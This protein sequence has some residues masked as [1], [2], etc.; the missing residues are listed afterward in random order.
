MIISLYNCKA[1]SHVLN[2]SSYLTLL[3]TLEGVMREDTEIVAP[4]IIVELAENTM[5]VVDD[6]DDYM[7][8]EDDYD[9]VIEEGLPIF[10]YAYIPLFHRYYFVTSIV[11]LSSGKVATRLFRIN[12]N[13]DVLMSFKDD[14]LSLTGMI[15]RNEFTYDPA[16]KDLAHPYKD[17]LSRQTHFLE[18]DIIFDVSEVVNNKP[19]IALSVFQERYNGSWLFDTL[20][21]GEEALYDL[22]GRKVEGI[23]DYTNIDGIYSRNASP[24][25]AVVTYILSWDEY[26]DFMRSIGESQKSFIKSVIAFPCNLDECANI[27][28]YWIRG[29]AGSS[30]VTSA[31]LS[32]SKTGEFSK[33][34]KLGSYQ[35]STY[36]YERDSPLS[37]W[38]L[39]VPFMGRREIDY[40][41]F[42]G[43][44]VDIYLSFSL[45]DGSATIYI[46][47]RSNRHIQT[48]DF[49]LGHRVGIDSSNA[50]EIKNNQIA[51]ALNGAVGT[52]ANLTTMVAGAFLHNPFMI[53]GGVTGETKLVSGMIEQSLNNLPQG[54]VS[55]QSS[56]M[57]MTSPMTIYIERVFKEDGL[58][59]D[60]RATYAHI[61][62]LPLNKPYKLDN[63]R[64][65]TK[66]ADIH[67]E[68]L[69]CTTGE[70]DTIYNFLKAG[71]IL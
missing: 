14:L 24:T 51:M 18:G 59:I 40:P 21:Q 58:S 63:L 38:Y 50:Q 70:K 5:Y 60:D 11:A 7:V 19:C 49:T 27:S 15:E 45:G 36:D 47:A 34:I 39:Y 30:G 1:D 53:A 26:F 62:G 67:L 69:T 28:N 9:I 32:Y 22:L 64:G 20:R 68:G 33:Y 17:S 61:Y 16:I 29:W 6:D 8:D 57:A 23:G 48:F 52:L 43:K 10:N 13:C 12:L 44:I 35:F 2:K 65:F 56:S 37:T 46:I 54:R 25:N 42:A 66:I 31:H 55:Q 41:S 3:N 71:V 4:S